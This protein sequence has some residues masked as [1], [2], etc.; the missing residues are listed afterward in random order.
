VE[1]AVERYLP[2]LKDLGR[3]IS[4]R[5]DERERTSVPA[6]LAATGIDAAA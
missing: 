4:A 3:T 5:L 1:Q 2:G 6:A